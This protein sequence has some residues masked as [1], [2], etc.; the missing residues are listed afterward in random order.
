MGFREGEKDR[1]R[2][3][4]RQTDKRIRETDCS[5]PS[6]IFLLSLVRVFL[7]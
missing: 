7:L 5:E 1:D 4:D 2:Q 6:F 3:T